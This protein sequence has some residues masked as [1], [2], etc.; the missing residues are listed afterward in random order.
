LEKAL[1]QALSS[2][3]KEIEI[4]PT[5]KIIILYKLGRPKNIP[6][7]PFSFL[8]NKII[9]GKRITKLADIKMIE[10]L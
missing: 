10:L 2:S 6:G 1:A 4:E 7:G 9:F 5:F 8:R 3:G